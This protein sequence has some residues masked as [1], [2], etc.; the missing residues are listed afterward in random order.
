MYSSKSRFSIRVT[1]SLDKIVSRKSSFLEVSSLEIHESG[2]PQVD[3]YWL[4]CTEVAIAS[5]FEKLF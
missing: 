1:K 4:V 3:L 5:L 2:P